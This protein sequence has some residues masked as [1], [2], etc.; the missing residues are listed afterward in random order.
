M[1]SGFILLVL[2]FGMGVFWFLS[3]PATP[4]ELFRARCS[5]CHTLPDLAGFSRKE[6]ASIVL[7]MIR[8][9]GAADVITEE[10]ASLIIDYLVSGKDN[11]ENKGTG[12]A[13]S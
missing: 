2:A 11:K 4:G 9:N 7:T 5:A 6:K 12:D 3:R 8:L 13:D 1:F 10:E